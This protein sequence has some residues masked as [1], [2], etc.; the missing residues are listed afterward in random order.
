MKQFQYAQSACKK[1]NPNKANVNKFSAVKN[2]FRYV[3]S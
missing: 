3:L 2:S 1:A